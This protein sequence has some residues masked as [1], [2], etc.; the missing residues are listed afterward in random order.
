VRALFVAAVSLSLLFSGCNPHPR[1]IGA[2]AP[3]FT[4][5]D[6]DRT[7]SL[8]ALRGKPVVLN[9]WTTWCPQCVEEMP[10]LVQ[11]QKRMGSRIT[12][13]AVSW[14][15]SESDYRKFL[16][17]HQID[18]LTVR[19]PQKMT[20]D[21][22]GATGQPETYIIDAAGKLRRKFVGPVAWNS[23]EIIEYLNQL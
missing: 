1:M 2:Q 4:V 11:L 9:F 13:L 22:Y 16:R 18:L 5:Q 21:L 17:D 19:D 15:A 12:V 20:S 8:H 10:S 6:S 7:V 14:D 3:D 23:P